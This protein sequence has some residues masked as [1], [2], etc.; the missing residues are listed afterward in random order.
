MA[1][2]DA[3]EALLKQFGERIREVRRGRGISQR[4][5]ARDAG[6]HQSDWSRL[7]RGRLDVRLSTLVRVQGALDVDALDALLGR[8][9]SRD[10]PDA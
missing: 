5:A 9:P 2:D 10:L 4:A 1:R 3:I 8:L 7:E 6:I